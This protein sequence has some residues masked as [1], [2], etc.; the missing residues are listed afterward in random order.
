MSTDTLIPFTYRADPIITHHTTRGGHA[1]GMATPWG[2]ADVKTEYRK[3]VVK[4]STSSHGGIGV[5]VTAANEIGFSHEARRRA[6]SQGAWLWFEED[7]LW[8]IAAW[9][10]GHSFWKVYFADNGFEA[11]DFGG[12]ALV[13][14]SEYTGKNPVLG[15]M[16]IRQYLRQTI[17]AWNAD[18]FLEAE[19][20]PMLTTREYGYWQARQ[21]DEKMRREKSPDLIVSAMRMSTIEP[22]GE[23]FTRVATAD[24]KWHDVR[25]GTYDSSRTPNALSSCDVLEHNVGLDFN[26]LPR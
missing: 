7:C 10:L 4:V 9:E 13:D 12:T 11:G 20:A 26:G 2:K 15:R 24:G 3:G 17:S 1:S 6:I 18:Y 8:A 23:K 19:Q 22:Y 14:A 16:P 5:S 21:L 25:A